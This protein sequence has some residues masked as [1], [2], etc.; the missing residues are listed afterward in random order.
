MSEKGAVLNYFDLNKELA[1]LFSYIIIS[2]KLIGSVN[3]F[4]ER[5]NKYEV[6]ARRKVHHLKITLIQAETRI[7]NVKYSKHLSKYKQEIEFY[8]NK[9]EKIKNKYSNLKD[10]EVFKNF[11]LDLTEASRDISLLFNS[12]LDNIFMILL[13]EESLTYAQSHSINSDN[14]LNAINNAENFYYKGEFDFVIH[15][16]LKILNDGRRKG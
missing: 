14:Y 9:L 13:A 3:Y 11:K 16:T 6:D 15:E 1:D 12:I 5:R 8:R 7:N 4:I 2:Y 10:V